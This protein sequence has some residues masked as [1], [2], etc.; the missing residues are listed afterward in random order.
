MKKL[1][2]LLLIGSVF[3]LSSALVSCGGDDD[4]V[5]SPIVNPDPIKP[6]EPSKNEAMT[7][8]EQKEY[9][10]VIARGFMD[11][12]PA[13]DFNEISKL[14]NHISNTYTDNYDWD[15]VGD[16]GSEIFE[17]LKESLGTTDKEQEKYSWGEYNY[18]YTNYKAL[19]MASNFK[20][21]FKAIGNKW[22]LSKADDLQFI[23]SDQ[24]GKEC[25]L[26]LVT[27]GNVK[28]VFIGNIDEWVDYKSN[29]T[30]DYYISN[31]YYDR[32][33]LTVGVP[34]NIVVTLTQGGSQVV[35]VTVKL[36]IGDLSNDKFDLSKNQLTASTLVEL[37]NGYKFNVSQVAYNGNNKTSVSFDMSKNGESLA[38][39]AFSSDISGIPSCNIDAM[40][41]GNI[42]E[43]DFNNS[44]MKNVYVKLDIMG[45]LQIQGTLSDVRKFTDYINEADDKDDDEKTFKSYV[46]QANSLA[47]FNLFYDG[48]STKQATVTLEAFEEESWNGMKYWYMEPM[49][50]FYDGSSYSTF[51]AFFNDKDFKSVIDAFE[52][53]ADN[54][55]SLIN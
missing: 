33:Q 16:W 38:S 47:N 26:K 22:E 1:V 8:L 14:C 6:E 45:K 2:S 34:E 36:N 28:K 24:Y 19:V 11:K 49:L 40:V 37:N 7:P 41:S 3:S 27:S 17:S 39:V 13:S 50:N 35:K 20:G 54:Y 48:K 55:A 42:D 15:E 30:D 5:D 9:L 12:T 44:N 43:E 46:N 18:I 25:V 29:S 21:Q 52:K 51:D 32:T 53:L 4:S 31:D 10:D 23:F